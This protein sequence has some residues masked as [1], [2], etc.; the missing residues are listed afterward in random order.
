MKYHLYLDESG[1]HGLSFIDHKFPIFLLCGVLISDDEFTLF[2]HGVQIIKKNFW[3][4][5]DIIFHSRDIRKCSKEF[6][7]LLDLE[8]K[9]KF[10]TELNSLIK[11]S[12]F[13]IIPS[14]IHKQHHI[15]QYGLI[16]S[17]PY[18]L[19]LSN[20][21][22]NTVR[23]VNGIAGTPN[24]LKIIIEKRG[25]KEDNQLASHLNKIMANGTHKI[26]RSLI[27]KFEIEYSFKSK[28]EN[29]H[30]LQLADLIAY[31]IA[32]FALN[33]ERE[34]LAFKIIEEKIHQSLSKILLK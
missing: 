17:D 16:S 26:S 30:G 1:D 33:N 32:K 22:D 27:Q 14:G 8:L 6:K 3:N 10:H 7:C 25:K 9:S 31:P 15:R 5:S 2:H 20:I 29:N 21:I 24:Q 11:K 23:I 34:N 4:T 28:K 19:C 18:E 12:I 13:T